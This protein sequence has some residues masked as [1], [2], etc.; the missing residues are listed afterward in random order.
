[1]FPTI[2]LRKG[3]EADVAAVGREAYQTG[4]GGRCDSV[5]EV[6]NVA[7]SFED[8]DNVTTADALDESLV[9]RASGC[10]CES[11]A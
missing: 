9:W 1:M 10:C 5:I 8:G 2:G 6:V 4:G 7:I 3:V 11:S